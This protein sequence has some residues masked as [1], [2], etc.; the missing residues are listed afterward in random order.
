MLYVDTMTWLP[1]DLLLKAD[2]I[3]MGNSLELRVPLLDHVLMQ[4]AAA[5]APRDKVRGFTT[6]YIL[7]K[8]FKGRVP[9]EILKR[10]KTGFPVP[11]AR[12]M[13]E[14]RDVIWDVLTDRRSAQRGYFNQ[15]LLRNKVLNKLRQGHE[16]PKELFSLFILEIWARTFLDG[17][18]VTLI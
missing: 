4:F 2:K 14:R 5:S 9:Q 1:D 15:S 11:Y 6:K 3:T 18:S 17:E 8:A 7:K 16:L 12:W 10:R 13:A